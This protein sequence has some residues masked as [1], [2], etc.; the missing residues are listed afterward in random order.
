MSTV[1]GS[2]LSKPPAQPPANRNWLSEVQ[3]KSKKRPGAMV[4]Y[5]PPGVGKTEFAAQ[6]PG[7]IFLCDDKEDGIN[8]LKE[9]VRG[10]NQDTPVL[11]PAKS[12]TDVIG[13]LDALATDKHDYKALVVDALG[14]IERL[15][16]EHVCR[17]EYAGEWGE[18]GFTSYQ[19][20]FDVSVSD[21]R[22][23]LFSLD[24][25]RDEKGMAILLLGHSKIS[26]F[27]NP[28]GP[29]FDRYTLDIHHK[30][31]AATH[32]W[33]DVVLFMNY[34][35]A[36]TKEGGKTKGRG[37]QQRVMH[38]ENDAAYEAKNRFGLPSEIDMGNCG[39]DAW[40]NFTT[41]IKE[42]KVNSNGNV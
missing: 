17:R 1:Q 15:C 34:V 27:K 38:T 19:R 2:R 29:D 40:S 22:Q 4:A 8:T 25:L 11:P 16:H 23:F 3:T 21:W 5:G 24:R 9:A 10:V 36:T 26:P 35:V 13:M 33:A 6:I 20:G 37:G 30:T 42:A 32:K 18:K 12:W 28:A 31:W 7:A 39:R 14:G 41:A